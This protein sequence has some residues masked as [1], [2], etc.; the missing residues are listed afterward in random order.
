MAWIVV[1]FVSFAAAAVGSF[2]GVVASRGWR[3]SVSGRSHCEACGRSLRWFETVPLVSF[4]VLRGRCRTCHAA[5]DWKVYAWEVG[6]A[7]IGVAV[8]A[9]AAVFLIR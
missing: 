5:V 9:P 3:A 7:I 4:L 8:S 2:A 6:G 1:A